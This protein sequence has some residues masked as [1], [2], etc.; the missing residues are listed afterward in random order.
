M[1]SVTIKN[2]DR[3]VAR[4]NKI[5][6]M[7]LKEKVVQATTLVHGQ[8]KNLA[9]V[10]T[11]NLAGSIRMEVKMA[12]KNIQGRVFTN[13]EYAPFVEFGTGSNG[14][15]TYPYKVKDLSLT[16]RDTPW[17]YSPDGGETFY[18][19]NGQP[20]QPYMYPA[21]KENEKY[22]KELLKSGVKEKLKESCK[23]G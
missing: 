19:T 23:G 3:L 7:D 9:P 17:V 18:Y 8:A 14:S 4:F 1:A 15:G 22:I 21:L 20:A 6:S 12:D 11:G 5:A 16:Y 10:D 2:V 13:L